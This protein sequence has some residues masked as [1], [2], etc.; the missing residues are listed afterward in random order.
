V[1]FVASDTSLLAKKHEAMRTL[2]TRIMVTFIVTFIFSSLAILWISA[3]LARLTFGEFFEGST[4]LELAQA[5]SVYET[6]GPQR[7]ADYLQESDSALN[8]KRYFTDANGRDLVSGVDRSAMLSTTFNFLGFPK[9]K[10]GQVIIVRPSVDGRYR[11]VLVAPPPLGLGR[12]IPYFLCVGGAI[13]LLGWVLSLG[14]VA[15]LHRMTN[16]VDRFGRG[17]L[18]IRVECDRQDEIGNLARTFNS[19]AERIETLLTAERRLLQDVSHELR[20]PLARLSFAAE[21]MKD[22]QD[23]DLALGRVRREIE[24]LSQLVAALL[25]VTSA[26]GD[27]ASRK[28]QRVVMAGLVQGIVSDCSLEATARNVS[29]AAEILSTAVV[30]GDPE[31]LHRAVE[32]VLRNAIRFA[33]K[34][35]RVSV[36]LEDDRDRVAVV[37]RDCGIGVPEELLGRI[38]DPFFCV[39][40]SRGGAERGAGLGLSIARRAVSLH[41]GEIS[42]DNASPGLRVRIAIPRV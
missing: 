7:L 26:E 37:I 39:D 16:S 29:I 21:L 2:S 32:N 19:M 3:R 41:R 30:Q 23:P 33:P 40:E 42:A 20:S 25:E 27:P 17:D 15:P 9:K 14:I 34:E 13:A 8:G 5:Q 35:S 31:L 6:L 36:K 10:N 1:R 11:L 28:T 22:T 4:K 18:S 38:F 24:R 12:F